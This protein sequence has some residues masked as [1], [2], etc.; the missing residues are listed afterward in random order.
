MRKQSVGCLSAVL[1]CTTLVACGSNVPRPTSEIAL[2]QSALEG[3]ES[4]GARDFAPI[5]LRLA[6][7]KKAAADKALEEE[8]F[9][10]ARYLSLEARVDADLA[11]ASAQAAKSRAELK[12]AQDGIQLLRDEAIP[13]SNAE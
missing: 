9:A 7:E 8:K 3:A 6:R 4:A 13:T 12:R 11:R 5:E 10:Q 1:F 2:S